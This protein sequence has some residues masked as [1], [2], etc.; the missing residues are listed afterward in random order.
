MDSENI[1]IPDEIKTVAQLIKVINV[2]NT[3]LTLYDAESKKDVLHNI[4]LFLPEKAYK[5]L[6]PQ[7]VALSK[8]EQTFQGELI[9]TTGTG[10][11]KNIF[12]QW[13]VQPSGEQNYRRVLVSII[14]ISRQKKAEIQLKEREK[15][16]DALFMFTPVETIV[17]DKKGAV[18]RYNKSVEK[19]RKRTPQPG[20]LM[21]KDFGGSNSVN[22]FAI[23]QEALQTGETKVI[24]ESR[25]H[26]IYLSIT[27]SPFEQG[28]IITSIDITTRKKAEYQIKAHDELKESGAV[29]KHQRAKKILTIWALV[30]IPMPIMAFWLAPLVATKFSLN[31]IFTLTS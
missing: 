24:P 31:P 27:I 21:Y 13:D 4:D 16:S 3:T 25:Y 7:F 9:N 19:K 15:F 29:L 22:M 6:I 18:V 14:D 5:Y 11:E 12:L 8:G 2:N 1:S 10:L 28:A 20:D 17:V 26:D 30:A 23:L